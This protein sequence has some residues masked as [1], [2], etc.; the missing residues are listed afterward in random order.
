LTIH[1]VHGY[2]NLQGIIVNST[3]KVIN[4]KTL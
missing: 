2:G 3:P 1:V 4:Q